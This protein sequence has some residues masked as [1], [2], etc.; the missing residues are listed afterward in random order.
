MGKYISKEDMVLL[1]A[2]V[3]ASVAIRYFASNAVV[4]QYLD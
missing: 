3:V 4:A 1:V 2:V